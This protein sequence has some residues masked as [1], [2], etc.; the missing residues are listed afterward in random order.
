MATASLAQDDSSNAGTNSAPATTNLPPTLDQPQSKS[1]S[2][3][4]TSVQS[5]PDNPYATNL[6]RS[7]PLASFSSYT[8]NLCLYIV[9]PDCVNYF[10]Q[11]GK[12]DPSGGWYIIAQSG[13][14]GGSEPRALTLDEQGV[15]GPGK[16]GLDLYIDD[17]NM[18]IFLLSKDGQRTATT[19]TTVTFK[20]VEPMGVT[21]LTRLAKASQQINKQSKLLG[22]V[23]ASARPNLYQQHYMIGV[24]FY[25]YDANGNVI[26]SRNVEDSTSTLNDKYAIFERIFPLAV[27]A[28]KTKIDGRATTYNFEAVV[29]NIQTAY[30]SKRNIIPTNAYI[31]GATVGQILGNSND[32]TTDSLL[33][34]LNENQQTLKDK[35]RL[36]IPNVYDIEW[37]EDGEK[38]KNSP[39]VVGDPDSATSAMS[40]AQ[41]TQQANVKTAEKT[42]TINVRSKYV[43]ISGGTSIVSIIDQIIVKSEYI[44]GKLLK[45]NSAS[46]EAATEQGNPALLQWYAINPVVTVLGRD[47]IL[48]DWAYKINYQ[49]STYQIPYIRSEYVTQRSKYYGPV[50]EYNYWLTGEN[51][52][53]ISYEMEYNN[54]FY[55][56]T[57]PTTNKDKTPVVNDPAPRAPTGDVN[58]DQTGGNLNNEDAIVQSVRANLYSPA[59]QATA[60]IKILGDPDFLMDTIS[61]K[62]P[63]AS[64]TFS[65][66]YGSNRA[67]SPYAGQIYIEIVFKIAEDYKDN[68]LLDVDP[69][70]TIAFYPLEQQQLLGNSGLIYKVISVKN[71][72]SRGKFEQVLNLIMVPPSQLLLPKSKDNQ[73]AEVR[74][75]DRQIEAAEAAAATTAGLTRTDYN[76]IDVRDPF[77][78]PA[79]LGSNQYN[80]GYTPETYPDNTYQDSNTS[81]NPLQKT[82]AQKNVATG[83]VS[84]DDANVTNG[85]TLQLDA[86]ETQSEYSRLTTRFGLNKD[87]NNTALPFN[88]RI[89]LAITGGGDE[90]QTAINRLRRRLGIPVGGTGGGGG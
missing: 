70:Q 86:R 46:I 38:I 83:K 34:W 69:T 44:S 51:T 8:Y 54:K 76:N 41:N 67:I 36:D 28:V 55:T 75:I 47:K 43:N 12:L 39:L 37:F 79:Q 64:S 63:P 82:Q 2:G 26:E 84:N 81:L 10:S 57:T 74:R 62:T 49:I 11:N 20:I 90:S 45:Q 61:K 59:D 89:N 72:L 35:F 42:E 21:F 53:V 7:N 73:R 25:G 14:I 18:E 5:T 16:P 4:K 65:R 68:G 22:N 30:G 50:K 88:Q 66:F 27:S 32:R 85:R 71:I 15:P 24:R 13:G 1:G 29:L 6:R 23:D 17:L 77:V 78:D 48:N 19:A 87:A 60:T 31:D 56:A 58:S 3:K 33:G 9:T 52:E 40:S 80:T